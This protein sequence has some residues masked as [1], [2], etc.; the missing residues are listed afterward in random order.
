MKFN[1]ITSNKNKTIKQHHSYQRTK[2]REKETIDNSHSN[3]TTKDVASDNTKETSLESKERISERDSESWHS[4][5]E[6]AHKHHI[7]VRDTVDSHNLD[8]L[9]Q[10][11]V[12]LKDGVNDDKPYC[13]SEIVTNVLDDLTCTQKT[14]GAKRKTRYCITSFNLYHSL[15]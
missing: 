10:S 4:E 14:S 6:S 5:N 15:D 2:H 11:D 1:C 3:V 9:E 12:P 13:V 8:I 7:N